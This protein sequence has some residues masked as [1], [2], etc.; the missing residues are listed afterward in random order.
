M[1]LVENV[2]LKGIK[3]NLITCWKCGVVLNKEALVFDD[4]DPIE[5]ATEWDGEDFISVIMCPVCK[6]PVKENGERC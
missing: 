6:Y 5:G 3:M 4:G 2:V 1:R